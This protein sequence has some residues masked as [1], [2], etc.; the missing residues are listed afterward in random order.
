MPTAWLLALC[1]V[2]EG[3]GS[4]VARSV[5][6]LWADVDP[7]REPLEVQEVRRWEDGGTVFRC[8]VY[9]VGTFKGR[10]ARMAAFYGFPKGSTRL[11]ALLH[12]HGGGQRAFLHEVAYYAGRGYACL[13][14]NWGGRPMEGARPGEPNTD[15][16]AV[17]PTQQNVPGYFN[18]KP[19]AKYL[20]AG[21][22]PRNNNWY[23][24]TIGARRGLTFLERQP[25]V[26]P[27]RLGV[28]GHSMGGNLTI[29][30]AGS[31]P[32]VKVAAPSA[33]GQGFRT[34][35]WPLLPQQRKHRPKGSLELFRATL[36]YQA[37]APRIR[38][39]VLWLGATNDFHGI[40]DDTYRTGA[41]IPHGRVRY[42]FA[43]HLNHRFTKP[44][45]VAR[46]LWLDQHLKGTFRFP[47]TPKSQLRLIRGGVP[48]FTVRPDASKPVEKVAVY[49]AV[50]PDPQARFWRAAEAQRQA[51]SWTAP[52]PV[53]SVAQP[54]FAFANV[55]YKLQ[56]A[57]LLYRGERTR[58]LAISSRLHTAMPGELRAAA[59]QA[60]DGPSLLIDDFT[61]G[62]RDWY[63][64]SGMNP[65]H[66]Q[67]WTRKI[68]DPKWRGPA[69][70]R[71]T[72]DVKAEAPNPLVVVLVENFFRSYR[73][74]Q[75]EYTAVV[76]LSG[77]EDWQTISLSPADFRAAKDGGAL[78]SWEQLD[79]LGFRAY[80]E[81]GKG[82]G[83]TLIGTR[84]WKGRQ[85]LFRNLRWAK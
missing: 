36:A 38:A 51:G 41:L 24:L 53:L 62:F 66:W 9:T 71:L 55:H 42:A 70:A 28:Y 68:S 22:S 29:Y 48:S 76:R 80:H 15:W 45:S 75:R 25:E 81:L 79:L 47:Q 2:G 59:V 58:T 85:P 39:P 31:D 27:R 54:L 52:L 77:A 69:R 6:A 34:Y 61:S 8:V 73:G 4:G 78:K 20:D 5:E 7:R 13:S 50:D 37:Y 23:L 40:M 74:K 32:R 72:T 26:D 14:I 65:H 21:E 30:V 83:A 64:L 11:P 1:C 18:P 63:V 33:G 10:K 35:P 67:Y 19:G 12:L 82:Q 84:R 57:E 16:G 46:P 44:F 49:Y 3:M 56:D 17:D 60:T 43:P